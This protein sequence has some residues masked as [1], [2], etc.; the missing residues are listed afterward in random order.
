MG[1]HTWLQPTLR[2]LGISLTRGVKTPAWDQTVATRRKSV[3]LRGQ[4]IRVMTSCHHPQQPTCIVEQI[5]FAGGSIYEQRNRADFDRW[6]DV[7]DG[8]DSIILEG[9]LRRRRATEHRLHHRRSPAPGAWL[10]RRAA[11][12]HPDH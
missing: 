5:I 10:F 3:S 6:L 9:S 2:D 7:F 8:V 12:P 11:G 1:T 4:K